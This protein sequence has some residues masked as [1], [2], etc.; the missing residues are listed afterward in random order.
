VRFDL[1]VPFKPAGGDLADLVEGVEQVGAWHH[2]PLDPVEALDIRVLVRLAG[3]NEAQI[4][5]L[6]QEA[7]MRLARML[8]A[9]SMPSSPGSPRR[10]R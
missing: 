1:V 7:I 2:F 4:D 10:S 9:T 5:H 6:R 3:L 8:T